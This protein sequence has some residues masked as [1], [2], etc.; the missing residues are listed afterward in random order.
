LGRHDREADGLAQAVF[1]QLA[2]GFVQAQGV[3]LGDPRLKA[4][5]LVRIASVGDRFSGS[6]YLT[7]T[8]HIYRP[9]AYMTSFKATG[10]RPQTL[11][12]LLERERPD[13]GGVVVGIVTNNDDP[14]G[15]GRVKVRLPWLADDEESTWARLVTPMAGD[16]RGL[17]FLPEVNDE[18]LVAFE[19]GDIHRPYILGGLWNGQDSPPE[20]NST[21]LGGSGQVIQRIIK[22][23][24]GHTIVL[25]DTDGGGGITIE[26]RGGNKIA[27]DS[28]SNAV[29]L[30]MSG[31]LDIQSQGKVTI[32]GQAGVDITSPGNVNVQGATINLN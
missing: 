3:A 6:Y 15:M 2:S 16:G 30:E 18:V 21:V 27:I 4:G 12:Q 32:S 24:A 20:A 8:S 31:N 25:D 19:H 7:A 11:T 29:R 17:Y 26:D 14:Q 10:R 28:G 13:R 22:T 9:D 5:Q 1:D 23:R